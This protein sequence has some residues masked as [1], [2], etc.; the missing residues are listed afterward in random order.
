MAALG[1]RRVSPF[2]IRKDEKGLSPVAATK[3]KRCNVGNVLWHSVQIGVWMSRPPSLGILLN[4]CYLPV[5]KLHIRPLQNLK[6]YKRKLIRQPLSAR[7]S[8]D[9]HSCKTFHRLS[10]MFLTGLNW[11]S[12]PVASD[13]EKHRK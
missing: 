11:T 3:D 5:S 10:P 12:G 8:T 7:C 2:T 1:S 4:K 13:A 9:H 6:L